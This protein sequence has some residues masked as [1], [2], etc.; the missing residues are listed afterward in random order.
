MH[1]GWLVEDVLSTGVITPDQELQLKCAIFGRELDFSEVRMLA[2]LTQ[3]LKNGTITYGQHNH[4]EDSI[5]MLK[6]ALGRLA[7]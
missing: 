2:K 7:A 3:G 5:V 6:P 1:L 4:W